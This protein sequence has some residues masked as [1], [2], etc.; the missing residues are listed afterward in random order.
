MKE[1]LWLECR[2]KR[3]Q[4]RRP[5]VAWLN[6]KQ[7]RKAKVKGDLEKEQKST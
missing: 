2:Q 6:K 7:S 5:S 1:G 3:G 4:G